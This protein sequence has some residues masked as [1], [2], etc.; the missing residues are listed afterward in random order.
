MRV[1]QDTETV[2]DE[3]GHAAD[4]LRGL[5]VEAGAMADMEHTA[6]YKR[7]AVDYVDVAGV[8]LRQL[9]IFLRLLTG[10]YIRDYIIGRFLKSKEELVIKS[11]VCREIILDSTL[12]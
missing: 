1:I 8:S 4:Y 12:H 2:G 3:M 11:P 10:V 9:F 7:G 6:E 5:F